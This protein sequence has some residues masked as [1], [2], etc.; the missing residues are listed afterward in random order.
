MIGDT[1]W[2]H[3]AVERRKGYIDALDAAAIPV[4]DDLILMGPHDPVQAERRATELLARNDAPTAIFAGNNRICMGTL[5]AATRGNHDIAIVGFDNL[6]LFVACS[7]SS[8][9]P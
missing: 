1:P 2:L 9:W 5:R 6:G 3:T 4:D 7:H 8:P